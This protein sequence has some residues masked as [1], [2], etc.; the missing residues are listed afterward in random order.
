MPPAQ[1]REE[2]AANSTFLDAFADVSEAVESG[3]GLPEVAR[4]A[5]RA[6]D[7]SVAVVDASA[8]VLAVACLSPEDE[9][10]VLSA[11]EVLELRVADT[12]A[13]LVRYRVRGEP[14]QP[15]LAL[16]LGTLIAQEVE[17]SKAPAKASEA[18]STTTFADVMEWR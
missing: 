17:R 4:A 1:Q 3:A 12:G 18:A 5:S 9:R 7:A 2:S 6:L 8:N 16:V 11:G 10:A 14:P 13:G 15:S